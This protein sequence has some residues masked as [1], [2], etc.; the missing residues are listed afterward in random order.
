MQPEITHLEQV[1]KG[2]KPEKEILKKIRRRCVREMD[3]EA[4]NKLEDFARQLKLVLGNE[5]RRNSLFIH[6]QNTT[7]NGEFSTTINTFQRLNTFWFQ[8][9]LPKHMLILSNSSNFNSFYLPYSYRI[10]GCKAAFFALL[11][12]QLDSKSGKRKNR[13]RMM[14]TIVHR[15]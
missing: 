8:E 15:K 4:D 5:A 9:S 14:V 3:R 6:D 10:N 11:V 7:T 2:L 13:L 1:I 12:V